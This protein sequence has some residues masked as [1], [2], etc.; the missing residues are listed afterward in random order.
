M[1]LRR[2]GPLAAM[3]LPMILWAACGQVYRPVVIP[4]SSGGVPGCPVETPPTSANFHAVFAISAN[5]PNAPG[6]AMQIDVAGD[7]V[8]AE[9]PVNGP[10]APNGGQNPTHAAVLPND[11]RLFV[12]SAGSVSGGVDLVSS[13]SPV[14]QT[15]SESGFG[16]L[17]APGLPSQSANITAIS[18][19]GSVVT[20][21]LSSA[22][23]NIP[24]GYTI[25]ITGVAIPACVPP[26]CNPNAYD[27][28]FAV[29]SVNG[30][31]LQFTDTATGLPALSG[32]QVAGAT[33]VFPPQ[34]V[35]LNSTQNTAMYAANYNANSVFV[36]NTTV[37]AVSNSAPVGAHPVA[38][39]EMP[40]ALK[41]YVANEGDNVT[42]NGSISSLNA[43][44]LSPNVVTG[45]TGV[46]PVWA[47]ARTDSQ[48]IYVV[49]EGDGQLVTID[50]A[51]DTVTSSLP[52]GA[53][54]NFIYYDS[55]L[56]RLYVTN[57]VT[58]MLY[59]FSDTGGVSGTG[60]VADIPLQIAAIS[61][62]ANS[63]PCPAG[64][65][66]VSV[67]ALPD[68][69]RFYVASYESFATGCPDPIIGSA[70]AC[71]VPGLTIFNANNF[72]LQY[73]TAPTLTLLT[74]PPFTVDSTT[75]QYQY[76]VPP[77]TACVSPV[78]PALYTPGATR[79]RVFT[80]ASVDGSRV[81]VSICDA[82][83]IAVINTTDSNIN[84]TGGT[85]TTADTVVN[86]LPA[87]FGSGPEQSNGEPANENPIFLLDGQ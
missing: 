40:D 38:L 18:E 82:G 43:Q 71:M 3:V 2:V 19:S 67:T 83:V 22:L 17:L 77:V 51:T 57:P 44:D 41:L 29:T 39:A 46:N 26:A 11:S 42:P 30:T 58:D 75:N 36:I 86:N 56:N 85:G 32:G 20:V 10:S 24:L 70:S 76:A 59:V 25:V 16:P 81:Y 61:F 7:A 73:P 33:A 69:S 49:T 23:T 52:V 72:A 34:P 6:G 14:F 78:F 37:F 53:G 21:T 48:K 60:A 13:F 68:G 12:A 47:V 27:G 84:N 65:S 8:I 15:S 4:C 45:F 64:C 31:T 1:K 63:A 55:H 9:T 87:A 66:P 54:A 50:T 5:V 62:A 35:F 28:A 74:D 80:T 79:F